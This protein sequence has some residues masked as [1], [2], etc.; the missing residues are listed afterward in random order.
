MSLGARGQGHGIKVSYL[1]KC[2]YEHGANSSSFILSEIITVLVGPEAKQFQL[3]GDLLTTHST[4]FKGCLRRSAKEAPVEIHMR[5]DDSEAFLVF[6]VWLYEK[7][8]PV[9]EN[10][11]FP[12]LIQLIRAWGIAA[13]FCAETCQ[14]TI[15][16]AIRIYLSSPSGAPRGS[17]KTIGDDV[18]MLVQGLSLSENCPLRVFFIKRF[19]WETKYSKHIHM[20]E[21]RKE[22]REHHENM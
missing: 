22:L 21:S 18:I 12:G 11:D 2:R 3:H 5:D 19:V 20:D 8:V 14:K 4:Y 9:P 10:D 7:Y 16:D 15:T 13:R 1:Y 17:Y 6:A